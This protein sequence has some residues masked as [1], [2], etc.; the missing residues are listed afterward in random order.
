MANTNDLLG[1]TVLN[2]NKK[3]S[4]VDITAIKASTKRTTKKLYV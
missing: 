4:G 3:T 2:C 1:Q